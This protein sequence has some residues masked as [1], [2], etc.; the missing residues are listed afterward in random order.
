MNEIYSGNKLYLFLSILSV[1]VTF[2]ICNQFIALFT[3]IKDIELI[4]FS[5]VVGFGNGTVTSLIILSLMAIIDSGLAG[6]LNLL[7]LWFWSGSY[8]AI[9]IGGTTGGIVGAGC[10]IFARL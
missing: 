5:G 2:I 1:I 9:T 6:L 8:I 4:V 7:G 3:H 10:A